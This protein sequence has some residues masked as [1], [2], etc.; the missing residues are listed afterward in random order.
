MHYGSPAE[1]QKPIIP[2][3]ENQPNIPELTEKPL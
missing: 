2:S 3:E 1:V